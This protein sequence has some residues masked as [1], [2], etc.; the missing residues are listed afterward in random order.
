MG[1]TRR[2]THRR[3]RAALGPLLA[4]VA[5]V[6]LVALLVSGCAPAS[7]GQWQTI[8]P[9][10]GATVLSLAVDP[11][12]PRLLYAGSSGGGIY[13]ARTDSASAMLQATGMPSRSVVDAVLPDPN[14]KGTVYAATSLGLYVSTDDGQTWQAHGRGFPSDD[15]MDA[16]ITGGDDHT[17]YA[18]SVGHGVYV[19]HDLGGT[20]QAAGTGLPAGANINAL[21][22]DSTTG[23]I[24]TAVDQRGVY[25]SND[26]GQTWTFSSAG[27]PKAANVLA[28]AQLKGQGLAANGTMLYAGTS[29]GIYASTDGGRSWTPLA[30][31]QVRGQV[32]ALATDPAAPDWLYA[33]VT[34]ADG[35]ND[36]LRSQDGGQHWSSVAPG[37]LHQVAAVVAG[38]NPAGGS[39]SI[40]FAAEGQI[41]RFPP[42]MASAGGLGGLIADVFFLLVFIAVS[43]WVF[44]R[45]RRYRPAS[46]SASPRRPDEPGGSA[47]TEAGHTP[48]GGDIGGSAPPTAQHN[49][50]K[51]VPP[52][53]PSPSQVRRPPQGPSG[54]ND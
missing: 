54:D 53:R 1:S 48:R 21:V 8:G 28:L 12:N 49:G 10:S 47:G 27:V 17:L 2:A 35:T 13:L 44:R 20:W 16:L 38:R 37:I 3:R 46:A 52:Q 15:T 19:S 50:H 33:G 51:P 26:L 9:G 25:V 40:L 4:M 6:G 7:A 14:R 5:V 39:G 32:L 41:A 45:S 29:A 31:D 23:A 42:A 22:R 11:F 43:L 34:S 24:W 36:V 30:Q 18:G